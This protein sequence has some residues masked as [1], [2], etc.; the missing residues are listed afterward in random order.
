MKR[1]NN[2]LIRLESSALFEIFIGKSIL[3]KTLSGYLTMRKQLIFST[4]ERNLSPA[5]EPVTSKTAELCN[6][7][8]WELIRLN[9]KHNSSS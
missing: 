4:N 2:R 8:S 1:P 3:K 6:V 5:C 9:L 7:L